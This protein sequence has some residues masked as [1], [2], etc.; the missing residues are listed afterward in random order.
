M[1]NLYVGIFIF[2]H[3]REIEK[4]LGRQRGD[5]LNFED[6][7]L[8]SSAAQ[9]SSSFILLARTNVRQKKKKSKKQE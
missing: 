3:I 1:Y 6:D 2:A 8:P 9:I 7:W 4:W 5:K